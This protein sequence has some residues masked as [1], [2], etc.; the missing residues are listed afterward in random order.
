[1][2]DAG[3]ITS[4]PKLQPW[5]EQDL[6]TTLEA[7]DELMDAIQDKRP[8]PVPRPPTSASLIEHSVAATWTE[9]SFQHAFLTRARRPGFSCLAPG[10][11]MW[12]TESFEA[13]HAAEP[14]DS[15]RKQ[16][17]GTKPDDPE[18]Y[19]SV[20]S[21]DLAPTLLFI[22]R[23]VESTWRDPSRPSLRDYKGR[24]SVLMNRKAGLYLCPF[25]DWSDAV[26]FSDGRGRENVFTYRGSC[27]WMPG[28]P[29]ALLRDVLRA[30][31]T[32][33]VKGHW[34]VRDVGVFGNMMYFHSLG[35]LESADVYWN[36]DIA[37]SF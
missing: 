4:G 3:K 32:I 1:M 25:E 10:M 15:E 20:L 30:W 6:Q 18:D 22:G 29:P 2:W 13:A 35:D 33:V 7:W 19:Q 31:K 36:W 23:A 26:V 8:K 21:R 37:T 9:Q 12:S 34:P 11:H 24:G 5:C 16:V 14:Q 27:P 17:I 28:R